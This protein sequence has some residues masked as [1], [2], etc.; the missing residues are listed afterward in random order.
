MDK[1]EKVEKIREKTGVSYAEAL[2]ALEQNDGDILDAIIYIERNGKGNRSQDTARFSSTGNDDEASER[3]VNATAEYDRSNER[4]GVDSFF[5]WVKNVFRKSIETKFKVLKRNEEILQVP[6]LVLVI[7]MIFA[8][9]I[10]VPLMIVGLFFD[11]RYHFE[12]VDKLTVDVN[13]FCDRAA[14]GAMD[15]RNGKSKKSGRND[16]YYDATESF[17]DEAD[18][19][20]NYDYKDVTDESEPI[21]EGTYEDVK[22]EETAEDDRIRFDD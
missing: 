19:N 22:S 7:A 13:G 12:G 20:A 15:M 5:E 8:F 21:T 18:V 16:R 17:S 1:L 14:N 4:D 2:M 11:C 6:V 9:W 3:L 10:I